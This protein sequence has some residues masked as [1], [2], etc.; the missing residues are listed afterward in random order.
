MRVRDMEQDPTE[1]A[2][3]YESTREDCLRIVLL[4]VGDRHL[5]QDLVAE[6]YTRAWVSWRK[7]RAL[8][9]PRAWVVRVA[10]NTHVSWWR[11]RRREVALGDHDAPMPVEQRTVVSGDLLTALR[12]LPPRQRDVVTLRLLLDMDTETTARVLGIAPGTVG[13]HLHQ[14]VAKLRVAIPSYY[15]QEICK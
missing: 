4:Y 1:F 14:A 6:A 12:R 15:G 10:L 7:V 3:F 2:D 13:A 8:G 11:R 5:A 9:V